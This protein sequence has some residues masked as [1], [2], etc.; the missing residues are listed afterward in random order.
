MA[1]K[2]IPHGAYALSFILEVLLKKKKK[3]KKKENTTPHTIW[4]GLCMDLVAPDLHAGS[5]ED[6]VKYKE[7]VRGSAVS[8]LESRGSRESAVEKEVSRRYGIG[9]I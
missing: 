7:R 5:F 8:P 9:Q 2:G 4:N 6:W 3:N 1:G